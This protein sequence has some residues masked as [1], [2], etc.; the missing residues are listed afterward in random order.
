MKRVISTLGAGTNY[1]SFTEQGGMK[2]IARSVTVKGGAG[3]MQRQLSG[4]YGASRGAPDGVATDMSDEDAEFLL[5]HKLF[6]QHQE[7]GFVRVINLTRDP[8]TEAQKMSKDDGSRPR[9][10]ADVKE[11]SRKQG[12]GKDDPATE[13]QVVSNKKK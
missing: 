8:N 6:K 2:S 11:F 13:L 3:V 10:A 12:L 7:R 9:N 4:V 1:A 5:N